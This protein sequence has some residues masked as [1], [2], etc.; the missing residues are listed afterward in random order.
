MQRIGGNV[1]TRQQLLDE[2]NSLRSQS[3]ALAVDAAQ[4]APIVDL[5]ERI[6]QRRGLDPSLPFAARVSAL[7]GA[8]SRHEQAHAD[9]IRDERDREDL[10]RQ[11]NVAKADLRQLTYAQTSWESAWP[12][13]TAQMHRALERYLEIRGA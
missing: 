6:E 5:L 11:H 2:A 10:G 4:L 1:Q 13:A 7:Q 3:N 9:F 12:A 8:I